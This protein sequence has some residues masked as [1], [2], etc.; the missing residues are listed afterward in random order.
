MA[1]AP[2]ENGQ[3]DRT[4]QRQRPISGLGSENSNDSGPGLTGAT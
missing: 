3:H 1:D 4:P 2:R